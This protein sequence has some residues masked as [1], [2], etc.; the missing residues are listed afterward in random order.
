MTS[1]GFGEYW[2]REPLGPNFNSVGGG[3]S[4]PSFS[5]D[6]PPLTPL[7]TGK[8]ESDQTIRQTIEAGLRIFA[9]PERL[10]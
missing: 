5:N 4:H 6:R 10:E 3:A 2:G 8:V 7:G 9:E 1:P